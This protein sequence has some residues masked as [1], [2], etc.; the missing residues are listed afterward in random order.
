MER[1]LSRG[2]PFVII[3]YATSNLDAR[4]RSYMGKKR[5]EQ[6]ELSRQFLLGEALVAK[7]SIVRG[8]ATAIS[9]IFPHP[10]PFKAFEDAEDALKWARSQLS[11]ED[12][13]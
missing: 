1:Y 7:S 3:H 6:A 10:H 4:T 13:T 12:G 2:E 5:K 11:K 9:W 8:A